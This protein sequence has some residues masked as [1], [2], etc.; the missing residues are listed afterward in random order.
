MKENN[1]K[2]MV[3]AGLG[4]ALMMAIALYIVLNAKVDAEIDC[5]I[6]ELETH[7]VSGEVECPAIITNDDIK[8]CI[9]PK[10]L[11]CHIKAS[12]IPVWMAR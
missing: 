1:T 9:V 4:F 2:W 11:K 7:W 5:E 12:G 6:K 10:D 3:L 8:L